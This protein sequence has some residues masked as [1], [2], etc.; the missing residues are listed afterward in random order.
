MTIV[1]HWWAIPAVVTIV[2]L[3]WGLLPDVG[4]SDWQMIPRQAFT[5]PVALV[6]SL[7]AWLI[8]ALCK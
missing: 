5:L 6:V 2:A 7:A 3:I 8:G 4:A 1:L